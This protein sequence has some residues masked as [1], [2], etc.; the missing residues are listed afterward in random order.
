MKLNLNTIKTIIFDLG[1]VVLNLDIPKSAEAFGRL[2]NVSTEQVF[3]LFR[4]NPVFMA[5]ER[6]EISADV[7]RDE[8]RR[9]LRSDL[10]NEA[11][12]ESWNA[13]LL[14]LPKDRITSIGNLRNRF[15]TLVLSNTNQIHASTFDRIV[16]AATGG[17]H[18]SNYFN[19]VYYSHLLGMRKP[20]AE[21]FEYVLNQHD[22]NP[23][24]T[25]F[26]DDLLANTTAASELGIQVWHLTDQR[27]LLTAFD[28]E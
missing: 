15:E 18:I 17:D 22:L 28:N 10:S 5:F 11:I 6:G 20:D 2:G 7:F 14:D 4:S 25:L 19:K 12:D 27:E 9:L 23:A 16:A 3:E 26:I 1:G 24:S 8:I 21:I 13:M